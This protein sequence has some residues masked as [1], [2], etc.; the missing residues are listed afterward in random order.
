[1]CAPGNTPISCN[2]MAVAA[3]DFMKLVDIRMPSVDRP[4]GLHLE[5]LDTIFLILKKR[6]LSMFPLAVFSPCSLLIHDS[7]LAL[8]PSWSYG[9]PLLH[10]AHWKHLRCKH[11]RTS[12]IFHSDRFLV[13]GSYHSELVGSRCHVL[14]LLPV[15]SWCS[16]LVEAVDHPS[17]DCPICH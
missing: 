5:L 1:M 4:F 6:P 16:G 10:P 14:V 11:N 12:V 8:L 7:L 3:A 13:L 2:A 9:A 15:C 17:P